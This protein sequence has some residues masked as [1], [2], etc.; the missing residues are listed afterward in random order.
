MILRGHGIATAGVD[1]LLDECVYLIAAFAR[2]RDE[3]LGLPRGIAHLVRGECLEE[4]LGQQHHVRIIA[5]DHTGGVLVREFLVVV[6]AERR[7]KC[8]RALEIADGEV[9]EYF[10]ASA[11]GHVVLHQSDKLWCFI[12][13]LTG[14]RRLF[15][16]EDVLKTVTSRRI[17]PQ[18]KAISKAN[19]SYD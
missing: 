4:R 14:G 7:E 18:T 13:K 11:V 2:Q 10:A 16:R 19:S 12:S 6:E 5:D 17:R 8:F 15:A 3:R 9:D 1:R